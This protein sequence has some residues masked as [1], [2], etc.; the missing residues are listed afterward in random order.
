M[1]VYKYKK[2]PI[3]RGVI[4]D[5]KIDYT[6]EDLLKEKDLEMEKALELILN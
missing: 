3:G 1:I 4:P 6:I 2:H 5:Y